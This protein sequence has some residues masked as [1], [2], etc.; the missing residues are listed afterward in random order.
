VRP[1][2]LFASA[3]MAGAAGC[4][5]F[6]LSARA[7][8]IDIPLGDM[9]AASLPLLPFVLSFAAIGAVLTSRVPRAAIATLAAV[10]FVSYLITEGGPL[11]KW[12][13]WVL[14]LSAFSLYGT[15]LTNGVYWLGLWILLAITLAGFGFAVALMQRR[16]VG[17]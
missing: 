3:T 12:P 4:V 13:A 2:A 1:P 17:Y 9:V 14:K 16:E 11:L 10:A 15:P 5:A 6:D 8:T 7:S